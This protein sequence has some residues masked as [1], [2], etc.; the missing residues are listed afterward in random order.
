MSKIPTHYPVKYKCGH[1]AKRDL[2][3]VP[4]SRRAQAAQ[5][6]FFATRAGKNGDGMVCPRC[7][8]ASRENDRSAFLNQLMLDTEAFEEEHQMPSL[9]GTEKMV[10]SGLITS[11]R[12]DRY[13]V[14]DEILRHEST[15]TDTDTD[16]ILTA[17]RS[18]TWAGWW[19]TNLGY[20]T[21]TQLEYGP[22]EYV[23]LITDGAAEEAKRYT[24]DRITNE[25]PHD[26]NPDVDPQ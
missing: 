17:A 3:K 26:W 11:A 16:K 7:F 15:D 14:L 1:T 4:P 21:R 24:T 23:E 6:D 22:E 19:T 8:A 10:T 13:S 9:E 2:S 25:N 20:K 5:S 18:L 12:R